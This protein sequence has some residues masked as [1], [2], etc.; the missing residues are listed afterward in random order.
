MNPES[1]FARRREEEQ[2]VAGRLAAEVGWASPEQVSG[3]SGLE[4]FEAIFA[5]RLPRPPIGDTLDFMPIRIERG[6]AVFQGRPQTEH[7]NPMGSVHGGWF[8][9]LLARDVARER[10]PVHQAPMAVVVVD[11]VVL[12]AAVVPQ[13]DRARSPGEAAGELGPHLVPE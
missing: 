9:T 4:V 1:T 10:D 3:L 5:G 7:Y 6:F 13:R 8:A 12:R 2:A 11:R